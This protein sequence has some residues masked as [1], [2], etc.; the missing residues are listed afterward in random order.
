MRV[1]A[2]GG[3]VLAIANAPLGLDGTWNHAGT[4]VFSPNWVGPLFRV[5]DTGGEPTEVTRLNSGQS[6]HRFPQ[7]LPDG[8]HFL[9]ESIESG[10]VFGAIYVGNIE[11]AEARA[12]VE[13]GAGAT[14]TTSGY[15]CLP[16]GRRAT[17]LSKPI[18]VW[19]WQKPGASG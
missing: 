19:H 12:L 14:Y 15:C 9:F 18:D 16:A 17:L 7:F 13:A 10:A 4:I 3:A 5:S 6:G 8:R 2:E 11:G 1:A